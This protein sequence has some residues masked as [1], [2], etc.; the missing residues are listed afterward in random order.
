MSNFLNNFWKTHAINV[1]MRLLIY[2]CNRADPSKTCSYVDEPI[3]I[4]PG[5]FLSKFPFSHT[6]MVPKKLYSLS[7][8]LYTKD[9]CV[10]RGRLPREPS[11]K[12]LRSYYDT[13]VSHFS[14][15]SGGRALSRHHQNQ[16]MT[17]LN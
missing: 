5:P 8:S 17:I 14:P 10:G 12:T 9:S 2:L 7:F 6:G 11:I 4:L 1:I 16:K 3:F 15:N 13:S